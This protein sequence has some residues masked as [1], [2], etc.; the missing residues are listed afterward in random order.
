MITYNRVKLFARCRFYKFMVTPAVYTSYYTEEGLH[1]P[2]FTDTNHIYLA[3]TAELIYNS[4]SASLSPRK[5]Y[6][7]SEIEVPLDYN[8]INGLSSSD[9]VP[10]FIALETR[11]ET[12]RSIDIYGWID[13]IEPVAV[14]GP[15]AN[16]RIKWHV[17][18]WLTEENFKQ[19]YNNDTLT[20]TRTP[21]S[22][23]C[24]R[25]RRGPSSMARPDPS[26][27]RRWIKTAAKNLMVTEIG[28]KTPW[29]VVAFTV[30]SGTNT[31]LSYINWQPGMTI[32]SGGVSYPTPS[33]DDVYA[34]LIE[35]RFG[36]DPK[37]VIGAWVAPMPASMSSVYQ[38]NGYAAYQYYNSGSTVTA[39]NDMGSEVSTS[40]LVKYVFED[41]TG[42]EMFTAPW[43]LP[44]RYI[45]EQ[46]D[47]GSSGANVQIYL[48]DAAEYT[49]ASGQA[50]QL[51]MASE[52]RL[53]SFP[54]PALPITENAWQSYNYSGERAYDM[55]MREIQRN[56]NA[57]NGIA[58][59]GTSAI[60]GAVAGSMVAP[61][62]GTV[63]GAIGGAVSS[64]V[65]TTVNYATSG[66][67]D[68]QTQQAVDKLTSSQTAGLIIAA[69][70]R[71]GIEPFGKT[72]EGFGWTVVTL[73]ADTES[74]AEL[75]AEQS[76]LGY[77][78]EAYVAD[79]STIISS[80]GGLRI[81]GLEV[82]GDINAKGRREI[83]ALFARG[84]HLDIIT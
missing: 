2:L 23:G 44:F 14:K 47:V 67:F 36:L 50:N 5:G 32:V 9:R 21:I 65:G 57:V 25:I 46:I 15:S 58:G 60:G 8:E 42:T 70:S 53:F 37:A 49:A 55:Q 13:D 31:S 69:R 82:K 41:T 43:G 48:C 79:C 83:S 52:G 54:L 22:Y 26:M 59:V 35:E 17:D 84:V 78:T 81:D 3:D 75:T 30:A 28:T 45:F 18:Y 29:V 56:Q 73:E 61:G 77:V 80:G 71:R 4:G 40:D 74:S 34:G 6:E 72:G 33:W 66:I 7:F 1:R 38:N 64:L 76:E 62:V 16:C 68:G 19:Y 20:G 39:I 27:P 12:G 10:R 11:L 51:S 63:A 24:G